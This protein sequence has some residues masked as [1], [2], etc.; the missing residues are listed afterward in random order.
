MFKK[1]LVVI[2]SVLLLAGIFLQSGYCAEQGKSSS[3]LSKSKTA[4]FSYD[5]AEIPKAKPWTS[6]P[7]KI[8]P[9]NF[10]FAII[11]D[12]GG[13]A[14]VQGTFERAMDQLNLLQPEFVINVGDLIEGYTNERA[15]I[16]AEWKEA[17]KILDKLQM[18]FFLVRGNHDVNFPVTKEA[19]R[20]RF[21]PGYYSFIYK[22]VLFIVLDTEDA[23]RKFPPN[24]EKDIKTYNKLKKEDPEA[25]KKW[26]VDWIKTPEAVEAF[27]HGV[28]VEFPD[29]QR[30]WLKKT[31]AEHPNVRWTFV[32]LHEPVWDN[33]SDSFKEIQKLLKGRKHTLF[34]GHTHYYDYDIVDGV[35]YITMGPVGAAFMK[36]GP[37]NVDH[38]MWVTMTGD[39]PQ[40][41]NIALK[42][43]YDRKG[44]D[45]AMFGAYDRAPGSKEA[46]KKEEAKGKEK[47][48]K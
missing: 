19:W 47:K 6:K 14:N 21:G 22:D 5:K 2:F 33:P 11:G 37:G 35:E 4:V 20:E 10:Q 44:L 15:E 17:E 1:W 7:F 16:E 23:E 41:G 31:L 27:G 34:A 30:A 45:P 29:K 32:F 43:L 26:L 8:N 40:M 39:G 42:G 9:D 13:G 3:K 12:R 24:M 25:A 38:I 28:K 46:K 36:Q 18:R 48:K